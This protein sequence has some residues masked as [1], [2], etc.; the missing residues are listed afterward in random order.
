MVSFCLFL[1]TLHG[2]GV[3][4]IYPE[5]SLGEKL[6]GVGGVIAVDRHV[7]ALVRWFYQRSVFGVAAVPQRVSGMRRWNL[8]F[9][10]SCLAA[11]SLSAPSCCGCSMFLISANRACRKPLVVLGRSRSRGIDHC[12]ES[13][14]DSWWRRQLC[15]GDSAAQLWAPVGSVGSGS[16]RSRTCRRR[17]HE[18]PGRARLDRSWLAAG[19][20]GLA[21]QDRSREIDVWPGQLAGRPLGN[22]SLAGESAARPHVSL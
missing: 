5:L 10:D 4:W 14:L 12:L 7:S 18:V 8:G 21:Q 19:P 6:V 22:I 20:R 9:P 3:T 1:L 15:F 16:R 2:K 11:S 17:L 13:A